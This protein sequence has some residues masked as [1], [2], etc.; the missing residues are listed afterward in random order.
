MSTHS[1]G[2]IQEVV[3]FIT[4][5]SEAKFSCDFYED[6]KNSRVDFR[7]DVLTDKFNEWV[8]EL[9]KT[10]TIGSQN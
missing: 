7:F 9:N 5:Q 10:E 4:I 2:I 1:G 8:V 3:R 6:E